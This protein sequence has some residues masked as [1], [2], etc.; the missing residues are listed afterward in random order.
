[1]CYTMLLEYKYDGI[2]V[3]NA[4]YHT[5]FVGT[6][7]IVVLKIN[8]NGFHGTSVKHLGTENAIMM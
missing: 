6:Q 3:T 5:E 7:L 4:H 2:S 1:M 8:V